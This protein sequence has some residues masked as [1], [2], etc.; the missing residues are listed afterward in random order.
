[1]KKNISSSYYTQPLIELHKNITSLLK[2]VSFFNHLA[3]RSDYVSFTAANALLKIEDIS[4][5][6]LEEKQNR[7]KQTIE[8]KGDG[9]VKKFLEYE[10]MLHEMI[11]CKCVDIFNIYVSNILAMIY[12]KNPKT[13][14]S[15]KQ[16]DIKFILNHENMDELIYAIAEKKISELTYKSIEELNNIIFNE[17]GLQLIDDKSDLELLSM[18][19]AIRNLIV[20]SNSIIDNTFL[21]IVKGCN[22][23]KGEALN[24]SSK[25]VYDWI[26]FIHSQSKIIDKKVSKKFSLHIESFEITKSDYVN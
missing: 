6:E 21:R 1:M 24:L 11:L 15:S 22:Q 5:G 18:I 10:K 25:D 3:I 9:A 16:I 20:H 23:T 8:E 14:S 2:M 4:S 19:N 7:Y 17:I 13:L 26:V 12:L